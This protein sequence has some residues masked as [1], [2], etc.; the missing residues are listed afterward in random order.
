MEASE[1]LQVFRL[2]PDGYSQVK[3]VVAQESFVTIFF[4]GKEIVT[5][6]CSPSDLDY[7]AA[8]FLFSE[9]LIKGKDD[10]KKLK[11][12]DKLGV[13]RVET[14]NAVQINARHTSPRL[15]T[16]GCGSAADFYSIHDAE[17]LK[18]DSRLEIRAR[19]VFSLIKEFQHYSATYLATHGTH[20]A[21]LSD[22]SGIVVFSEDTGR[23]NAI[24]KLF[25]QCLLKDIPTTDRLVLTSGRVSFEI[26]QKIAKRG[27]PIVISISAPLSIGIKMADKL[28]VTLIGSVRGR[29]MYVYSHPQR[30]IDLASQIMS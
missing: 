17:I 24:D 9:Y 25:G 26:I 23:H 11:V 13:V 30:V 1:E 10:I 12:D 5:L 29:S 4:N 16:S 27:V 15:I 3:A 7:L 18:V 28:G 6:L 20:S 19:D 8:G 21:A 14:K 22:V 2:T